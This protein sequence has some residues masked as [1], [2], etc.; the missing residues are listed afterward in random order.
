MVGLMLMGVVASAALLLA[1]GRSEEPGDRL[2]LT[3]RAF[4][5]LTIWA[6]VGFSFVPGCRQTRAG[7]WA[8]LGRLWRDMSA[9]AH[10]DAND[11]TIDTRLKTLEREMG[12]ALDATSVWPEL[13]HAF[14]ERLSCIRI[15]REVARTCYMTELPPGHDAMEQIEER[16]GE[17]EQLVIDQ[18]L[19]HQAASKA[20]RAIAVELEV[21]LRS[22]EAPQ[23]DLER[24]KAWLALRKLYRDGEVTPRPGAEAAA[25]RVAELT[26]DEL[27]L[28]EDAPVSDPG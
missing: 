17:L 10:Q 26:V 18:Q 3:R 24:R 15:S 25:R 14:E 5:R 19:T 21:S 4:A 28:L 23:D 13:R 7:G 20:A 12:Q 6:A 9:L 16:V 8:H 1:P 2:P 22:E 27:G 11:K